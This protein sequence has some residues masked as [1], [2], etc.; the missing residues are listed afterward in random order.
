MVFKVDTSS[1]FSVLYNF[2]G[3]AD[4]AEPQQGLTADPAGNLYD[5]SKTGGTSNA[6]VIFKISGATYLGGTFNS[7]CRS[8]CGVIFRLRPSGS[9]TVFHSFTGRSD[10]SFP[11]SGLLPTAAGT[12]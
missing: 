4:S 6:G 8:G 5:R 9:H 11:N 12:I 7:N 2:T 1:N 10:G 3:G